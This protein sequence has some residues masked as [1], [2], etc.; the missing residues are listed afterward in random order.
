MTLSKLLTLLSL[1]ILI[2]VIVTMST[3]SALAWGVAVMQKS[4]GEGSVHRRMI[5]EFVFHAREMRLLH[6]VFLSRDT[7][8]LSF[9]VESRILKCEEVIE[10]MAAS[11]KAKQDYE[12]DA[13]EGAFRDYLKLADKV[14]GYQNSD[15][16]YRDFQKGSE[17]F[18]ST[19]GRLELRAETVLR[20]QEAAI[21]N[22]K[23]LALV[24]SL[25][26][27]GALAYFYLRTIKETIRRLSAPIILLS[28]TADRAVRGSNSIRLA[29]TEVVEL[30]S[31]GESLQQFSNQM[32]EL[33]AER[34]KELTQ[35]NS[36]LE[37]QIERAEEFARRA[38]EAEEAKSNFLASMSH[39]IRTPM[40]GILGMNTVLRETSLNDTQRRYLD[41]LS[42]CSETLMVLIDD[43]L[44]FSKI[45][46]G[47]L[48][49]DNS[50]FDL[51]E[52]ME[53][54]ATLFALSASQK[55]LDIVVLPDGRL[56][57]PVLG[58][59]H[60][61]KQVLSNLVSNA[62]KFTERGSIELG[63]EFETEADSLVASIWVRDTGIGIP[64]EIQ[65]KL[66]QA[67]SQAD[68]STS[69][70]FGG[71]G[72]G[73]VIS[74]RLVELM[75]GQIGVFSNTGS[76]SRFWIRI[77]FTRVDGPRFQLGDRKLDKLS[78]RN[79]LIV[80]DRLE[81]AFSLKYSLEAVPVRAEVVPDF[82]SSLPL[83]EEASLA[84]R[85]FT[86][87]VF[88]ESL[89]LGPWKACFKG[90]NIRS[91][92]LTDAS[93]RRTDLD[94]AVS[95]IQLLFA[96]VSARRILRSF[97]NDLVSSSK[98]GSELQSLP[99]FSKAKILVVDDNIANRLV[100]D[101]LFKRHGFQPDMATS[102]LEA[103]EATRRTKYDIIFMDCMMPELDGFET[104]GLIRGGSGGTLCRDS[105]IIALTANA[106][107]GDRDK[108]LDAGMDD[109]LAKPI[110]PKVL[111]EKLLQ[112]LGKGDDLQAISASRQRFQVS[113][114]EDDSVHTHSSFEVAALLGPRTEA[115]LFDMNELI[116]MFGDDKELIGS[117]IDQYLSG[118]DET[119]EALRLAIE[120]AA[121]INKA[122]LHSH[123]M[124][125]SSR[126]FGANRL[127]DIADSVENACLGND[128]ESVERAWT[129]I[130]ATVEKTKAA[131]QRLVEEMMGAD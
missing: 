120:D 64:E 106:M 75:N 27:L 125:G 110:R 123:T 44:D 1:K 127:G 26:T 53:E 50:P 103:I 131:A 116:G 79:V 57:E 95:G 23:W 47:K 78:D 37:K 14:I 30:K 88:D 92:M 41:T 15:S 31:L 2:V 128:W 126:S 62:I 16:Y 60:R 129:M 20:M 98:S 66:F 36:A 124:K 32:H 55:G 58:D 21:R 8:Y 77:P 33:V 105:V 3:I 104:T 12:W 82:E 99:Q 51:I 80:S 111:T 61:L 35:S 52:V 100:A 39:E 81:L 109:Y 102:G 96:P 76:G 71:T 25:L 83:M 45:E 108:C 11:G 7:D 73:L 49:M 130:P 6:D 122:R 43:I 48:E 59:S 119:Y 19:L 69:R 9:L 28:R 22:M 42:N 118:L 89:G 54:V 34:T 24:G 5:G 38:K 4:S 63:V 101:E 40:N 17:A 10:A 84:G 113:A 67:F 87:V 114:R 117:L 70:K 74:Q 13:V 46:A 29:N 56:S 112:V 121:D 91:L 85:A 107:S 18:E 90:M 97:L 115:E 72:L 68:G 94:V 93:H 86:D 65:S